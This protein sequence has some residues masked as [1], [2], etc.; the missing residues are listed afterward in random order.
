[1]NKLVHRN[2]ALIWN[3][4]N[5]MQWSCH[6][7]GSFIISNTGG[8]Q[9]ELHSG[10]DRQQICN[11]HLV[12]F[13]NVLFMFLELLR[14]ALNINI[15]FSYISIYASHLDTYWKPRLYFSVVLPP[16]SASKPDAVC[17]D[18]KEANWMKFRWTTT[19]SGY[20]CACRKMTTAKGLRMSQPKAT[21]W[22]NAK[23]AMP[24]DN[25]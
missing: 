22:L 18:L 3:W 15:N 14:T 2:I 9:G 7:P 8:W 20:Y 25:L 12:Y 23:P 10:G 17:F 5:M 21:C 6:W 13:F 1:M 24:C 11:K 16:L 19:G 4:A